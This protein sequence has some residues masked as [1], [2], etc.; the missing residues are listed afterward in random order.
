MMPQGG[1]PIAQTFQ[2]Q[3]ASMI[4]VSMNHNRACWLYERLGFRV[5]DSSVY[6][7]KMQWQRNT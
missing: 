7:L 1:N 5:I 3:Q 2:K 4:R 6:K